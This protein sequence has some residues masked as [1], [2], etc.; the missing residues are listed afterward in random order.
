MFGRSNPTGPGKYNFVYV[1]FAA[2]DDNFW[3]DLEAMELDI[4]VHMALVSDRFSDNFQAALNVELVSRLSQHIEH[5]GGIFVLVSSAMAAFPSVSSYANVRYECELA[6]SERNAIVLRLAAIPDPSLDPAIASIHKLAKALP[7]LPVPSGKVWCTDANQ[8]SG[9]LLSLR[10]GCPTGTFALV[11]QAL[12]LTSLLRMSLRSSGIR[13]V[14]V[15]LPKFV[16]RLVF[17]ASNA[18]LRPFGVATRFTPAAVDSIG[19]RFETARLFPL[20][21]G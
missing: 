8:V 6:L 13:A 3:P 1:D 5:G 4:F 14:P 17:R 21:P 7:L 18:I 10:P 16:F 9:M 20:L 15:P 11:T 19:V 2:V 12:S